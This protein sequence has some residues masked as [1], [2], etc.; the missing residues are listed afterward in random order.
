[1]NIRRAEGA[2][3]PNTRFL[4]NLV[5]D[6]DSHNS[7]LISKEAEESRARLRR[8]RNL[9]D[10]HMQ[11]PMLLYSKESRQTGR[12]ASRRYPS[13]NQYDSHTQ[14]RRRSRSPAMEVATFLYDRPDEKKLSGSM[15]GSS[16]DH[17]HS[18]RV[19]LVKHSRREKR[20]ARV[21]RWD[22]S[23]GNFVK[24]K[25][26]KSYSRREHSI[27]EHPASAVDA[28][29]HTDRMSPLSRG[30][31]ILDS[32]P[33]SFGPSPP[34]A[35]L[36]KGR[37]ATTGQGFMD[38]RFSKDYDPSVDV[39]FGRHEHDGFDDALEAYR[40]RQK[41][42]QQGAERFRHVGL[43]KE[44]VSSWENKDEASLRW[45]KKGGTRE[46]DRGKPQL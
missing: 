12:E 2:P 45:I 39:E 14:R 41:W 16:E 33:E 24:E 28:G 25:Q 9:N 11:S 21:R 36:T 22:R 19:R 3:K 13:P 23:R 42:K 34:P 38:S 10:E 1:V 35:N 15:R 4:R 30:L 27:E 20:N 29:T 6:A 32:S 8:M 26:R 17:R 43:G 7:A 44:F 46:W 37:G 5:R 18:D 31:P 40:D